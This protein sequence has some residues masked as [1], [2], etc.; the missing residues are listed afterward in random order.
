M[1]ATCHAK[2][3][4]TFSI[5]TDTRGRGWCPD[6]AAHALTQRGHHTDTPD[7]AG[8]VGK[9]HP[10]TSGDRIIDACKPNPHAWCARCASD[11]LKHCDAVL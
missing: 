9:R 1:A 4:G 7:C 10:I 5:V 2:S 3:C 6:H 8:N 11:E